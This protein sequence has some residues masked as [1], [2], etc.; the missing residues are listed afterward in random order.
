[1]VLLATFKNETDAQQLGASLKEAGIDY[2]TETDTDGNTTINVF[3]DD[4][5]EAREIMQSRDDED[6]F[7]DFEDGIDID[8]FVA[9]DDEE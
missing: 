4:V 9:D 6:Y 7:D 2:K 8:D 5:E 1:M 3:D